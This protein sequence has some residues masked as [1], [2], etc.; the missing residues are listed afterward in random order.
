MRATATLALTAAGRLRPPRPLSRAA[1]RIGLTAAGALCIPRRMRGR[2]TLNLTAYAIAPR[3]LGARMKVVTERYTQAV[4]LQTLQLW[5]MAELP[6]LRVSV[7]VDDGP[8]FTPSLTRENPSSPLPAIYT[9]DCRDLL[10]RDGMT[11]ILT[12]S[13]WTERDGRRSA[14]AVT[15]LAA[16]LA[17][18][19]VPMPEWI[20][21]RV[22][23]QTSPDQPDLIEIRWRASTPVALIAN[24]RRGSGAKT[25][26]LG[27]SGQSPL[28]VEGL[29]TQFDAAWSADD[30]LYPAYIGA[31]GVQQG[32]ESPPLW[33]SRPL[34]IQFSR[35]EP[36]KVDLKTPDELAGTARLLGGITKVGDYQYNTFTH[37]FHAEIEAAV[38]AALSALTLPANTLTIIDRALCRFFFRLKDHVRQ[39]QPVILDDLGRF[40]ATWTKPRTHTDP[41]TGA[42]TEIPA[43]RQVGFTPSLGFKLGT[44]NGTILTDAQARWMSR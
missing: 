42:Q 22:I 39:D 20:D 27:V 38:R 28:L 43:Q 33:K 41:V 18:E 8:A 19:P 36:A 30:K 9:A 26:R 44:R 10:P 31:I 3:G 29:G 35:G 34:L 17:A 24:L 12:V 2:A 14:A 40:H 4:L 25:V 7:R 23:R 13:A 16:K 5:V 32:R 15:K 1:A 21:A 11:H 37:T 6:A